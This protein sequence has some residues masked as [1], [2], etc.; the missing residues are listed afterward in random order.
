MIFNVSSNPNHSMVPFS[1]LCLVKVSPSPVGRVSPGFVLT[2]GWTLCS[3]HL[4]ETWCGLWS[5]AAGQ[6]FK[7]QQLQV[8]FG[9]WRSLASLDSH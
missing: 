1:V 8:A 9:T 7:E 2:Q 6:E 3:H 4:P 5:W